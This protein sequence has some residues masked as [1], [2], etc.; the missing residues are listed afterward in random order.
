MLR[1]EMTKTI[2]EYINLPYT[3]EL[4]RDPDVG[5]FV[6]V[7]ELPGCMSQGDTAEEAL[8]MI[9]DAMRAWI[10]IAIEDGAPIP[11]PRAEEDYSGKFVVR[12]PRSL[13]HALVEAAARDNVSLNQYINVALAQRVGQSNAMQAS[14]NTSA[15]ADLQAM[16]KN[17]EQKIESLT[18]QQTPHQGSRFLDQREPP[19]D[20]VGTAPVLH[21]APVPYQVD[22]GL[23]GETS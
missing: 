23:T 14:A 9:Q 17:L 4:Q 5:W 7:R 13:H 8:T 22:P 15:L 2:E 21:E 19:T 12:V 3:I 1:R 16:L 6:R 11:E 20:K 18:L 10:E